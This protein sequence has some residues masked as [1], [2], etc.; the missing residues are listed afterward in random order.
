MTTSDEVID[1]PVGGP[2]RAADPPAAWFV[3]RELIGH[4]QGHVGEMVT[5]ATASASGPSDGAERGPA[6]GRARPI[7]RSG[8]SSST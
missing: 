3:R 6:K 7:S 1:L 5:L 4:A 8:R 2:E